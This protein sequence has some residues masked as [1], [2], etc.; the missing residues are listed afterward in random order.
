MRPAPAT[1][2]FAARFASLKA[3][4]VNVRRGPGPDHA[5]EWV[6]RQA[7]LPVEIIAESDVW[8]R[9]RDAEGASGWVLASLLSNRRTALVEPWETK[10]AGNRPQVS[11]RTDDRESAEIVAQVEA[12][13]VANIQRCDGRWCLVNVASFNGYIQQHRLWGVYKGEV[14]K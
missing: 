4:R 2:Q 6:Y 11:L 1:P 12:G 8:R 5:I 9:V 13:V 10:G 14:L 7:G 3:D